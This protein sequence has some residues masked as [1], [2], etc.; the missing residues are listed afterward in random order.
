MFGGGAILIVFTPESL[1][2]RT[3]NDSFNAT[4]SDARQ[5]ILQTL[6]SLFSGPAA[7]LLPGAVLTIP[8]ASIQSELL[9]RLMPFQFGWSLSRSALVISQRSLVTLVTLVCLL[10]GV[11]LLWRK[12]MSTRLH[13]ADSAMACGS[14]TLVMIGSMFLMI[15]TE[16]AVLMTGLVMSALGSGLPTLCRAMLVSCARRERTGSVFGVLAVGELIGFLAFELS[17]GSLFGL[18]LRSWMGWPFCLGMC[19]ALMIG[20]ATWLAPTSWTEDLEEQEL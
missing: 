17:M 2:A 14:A 6:K 16:E 4:A 8:L 18:G 3:Y 12:F 10:P 13:H 1:P 7:W 19:F 5:S 15:I 9:F 11:A 20:C